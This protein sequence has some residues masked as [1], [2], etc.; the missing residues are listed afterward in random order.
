MTSKIIRSL[1]RRHLTALEFV[2][3]SILLIIIL[4]VVVELVGFGQSGLGGLVFWWSSSSRRS[5]VEGVDR[6]WLVSS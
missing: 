4:V 1:V 3:A 5:I 6:R 2:T